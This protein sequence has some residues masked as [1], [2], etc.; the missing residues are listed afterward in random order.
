[1]SPP[2]PPPYEW[3][4]WNAPSIKVTDFDR[5]THKWNPTQ[6]L[7]YNNAI[8]ESRPY[9]CTYHFDSEVQCSHF[10]SQPQRSRAVFLIDELARTDPSEIDQNDRE[11][12]LR[13]LLCDI[14]VEQP[15]FK[16]ELKRTAIVMENAI[17]QTS[18]PY[19]K[20]WKLLHDTLR[21]R[22]GDPHKEH[23]WIRYIALEVLPSGKDLTSQF[24]WPVPS[25]KYDDINPATVNIFYKKTLW[26]KIE[27]MNTD[28]WK[29][30]H[31]QKFLLREKMWWLPL[32]RIFETLKR[33]VGRE[34]FVVEV[35]EGVGVVWGVVE[36]MLGVVERSTTGYPF[37]DGSGRKRG[38]SCV[39]EG[40]RGMG[41]R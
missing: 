5:P 29:C 26:G 9:Q 39:R 10:L 15:H 7:C 20:E 30:N 34:G 3:N 37:D 40:R 38:G 8:H 32:Q 36:E 1:M 6:R 18:G 22:H 24:P 27:G 19:E 16:R 23:A 35:A 31:A 12:L 28:L 25:G 41:A 2:P 21:L 13:N 11:S 14:H 33:V 4:C 17:A